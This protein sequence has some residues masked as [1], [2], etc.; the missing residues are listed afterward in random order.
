MVDDVWGAH[1]ALC[2]PDTASRDIPPDGAKDGSD[3]GDDNRSDLKG[4]SMSR[5]TPELLPITGAGMRK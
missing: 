4:T 2:P 1:G 5:K 3:L